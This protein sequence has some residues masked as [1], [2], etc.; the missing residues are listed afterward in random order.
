LDLGSLNGI[1]VPGVLEDG[2]GSGWNY[3]NI[4]AMIQAAGET[5]VEQNVVIVYADNPNWTPTGLAI[6]P[7]DQIWIDTHASGAWSFLTNGGNQPL[8]SANGDPSMD[9]ATG[10]PTGSL[11]GDAG[12]TMF[13]LGVSKL[14]YPPPATGPLG[15]AMNDDAGPGA[16][17]AGYIG[18]VGEQAV[19]VI[20]TK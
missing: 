4:F 19:R 11:L 7:G 1:N 10:F 15:L 2:S 20:V 13:M 17:R 9:N 8:Y 18:N 6:S 3:P 14:N 12:N 5:V 16:N